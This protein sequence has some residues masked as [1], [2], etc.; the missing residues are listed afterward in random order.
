[1]K[2]MPTFALAKQKDMV[3]IKNQVKFCSK[4]EHP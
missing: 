2:K 1:M 3:R 4:K